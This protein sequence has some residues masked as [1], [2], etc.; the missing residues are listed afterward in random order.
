MAACVDATAEI[1]MKPFELCQLICAELSLETGGKPKDIC[2]EANKVLGRSSSSASGD[3]D[4]ATNGAA[5]AATV[6]E[7]AVAIRAAIRELPPSFWGGGGDTEDHVV[8]DG[9]G[10]HHHNS[11][12]AL[13]ARLLRKPATA[14]GFCS[15]VACRRLLKNKCVD[16]KSI[17]SRGAVQIDGFG[18]LP[19]PGLYSSLEHEMENLALLFTSKQDS[20]KFSHA[21]FVAYSREQVVPGASVLLCK[22]NKCNARLAALLTPKFCLVGFYNYAGPDCE[23]KTLDLFEDL[24]KEAAGGAK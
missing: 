5:T 10:G 8:V 22:A 12:E 19:S 18:I 9:G 7:D 3:G 17:Y 21:V 11:P 15:G 23:A 14:G 4:A 24:R 1:E 2:A 13:V 16:T 20:T 6:K